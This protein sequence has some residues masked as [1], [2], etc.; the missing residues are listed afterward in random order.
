MNYEQI[1]V[2]KMQA[3]ET[4]VSFDCGDDDLNDFMFKVAPLYR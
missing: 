1:R 3:D 2:R 4:V